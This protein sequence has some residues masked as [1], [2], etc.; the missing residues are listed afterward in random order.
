MADD[1]NPAAAAQDDRG[2]NVPLSEEAGVGGKVDAVLEKQPATSPV[3]SPYDRAVDDNESIGAPSLF[4]T[5]LSVSGTQTTQG[6]QIIDSLL[7]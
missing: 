3:I 6:S 2:Q 4:S 5:G 7:K 1:E